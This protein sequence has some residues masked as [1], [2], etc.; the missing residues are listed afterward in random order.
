MNDLQKVF[1]NVYLSACY[2]CVY[3]CVCV[4]CV[5]Y[6]CVCCVCVFVWVGVSPPESIIKHRPALTDSRYSSAMNSCS[7]GASGVSICT[8]L[9]VKQVN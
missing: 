7:N 9:L 3:V 4:M 8:H 1:V 6:V 5:C 2:V